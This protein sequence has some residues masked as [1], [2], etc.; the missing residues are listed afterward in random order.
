MDQL[1]RK[2][3]ISSM[4]LYCL[5]GDLGI[6]INYCGILISRIESYLIEE[7]VL[8]DPNHSYLTSIMATIDTLV[9]SSLLK[10]SEMTGGYDFQ[11]IQKITADRIFPIDRT[12]AEDESMK[13]LNSLGDLAGIRIA[14]SYY[15]TS[16]EHSSQIGK[17]PASVSE[18]IKFMDRALQN[19]VDIC[20]NNNLADFG[21]NDWREN[22][23]ASKPVE[24]T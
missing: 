2:N 3:L 12:W 24:E 4:L 13:S 8:K 15:Y 5:A 17:N 9:E 16:V 21:G 20:D 23:T 6:R 1:A 18:A 11:Q 19:I 7:V 22:I 14:R 10:K